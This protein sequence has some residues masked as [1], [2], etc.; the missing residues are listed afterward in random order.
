MSLLGA[1]DETTTN[2]PRSI[3]ILYC[4]DDLQTW[5]NLNRPSFL[6]Y[7]SCSTPCA[8][9]TR[10]HTRYTIISFS[11]VWSVELLSSCE[12]Q[13]SCHQSCMYV[14]TQQLFHGGK[15]MQILSLPML[16]PQ[17]EKVI[18]RHPPAA[19]AHRPQSVAPSRSNTL[20][21]TIC[22]QSMSSFSDTK[23]PYTTSQYNKFSLHIKPSRINVCSC[24]NRSDNVS[25]STYP[26]TTKQL[27][28]KDPA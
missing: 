16:L 17:G 10:T 15:K 27:V 23:M 13:S 18:S 11:S 9:G 19:R 20:V 22:N 12:K 5:P 3:L 21:R 14:S 24:K 28:L 2:R 8:H 7:L 25:F 26:M 4:P 1:R 6:G